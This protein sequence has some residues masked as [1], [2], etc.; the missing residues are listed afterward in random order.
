[1]CM[2]CLSQQIPAMTEW[3]FDNIDFYK[4][5]EVLPQ[6]VCIAQGFFGLFCTTV[7][8]ALL[9]REVYWA[10]RRKYVF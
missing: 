7:V 2:E 8:E 9:F 1:M 4:V 10:I 3:H 6:A 5:I